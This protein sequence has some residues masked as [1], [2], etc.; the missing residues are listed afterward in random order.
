MT[1]PLRYSTTSTFLYCQSKTPANLFRFVVNAL[2]FSLLAT[3]KI[4]F[5]PGHD[6]TWMDE[7]EYDK[8]TQHWD[9]VE[10]VLV[11]LVGRNVAVES[12]SVFAE[13]ENNS[14]LHNTSV[15]GPICRGID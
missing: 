11:G 14:Y 8:A 13:T 7:I 15:P 5:F 6:A 4:T 1:F 2:Y 12:L 3:R 9:R 10:A